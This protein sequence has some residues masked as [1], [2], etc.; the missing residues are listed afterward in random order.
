MCSGRASI[1]RIDVCSPVEARRQEG[2]LEGQHLDQ[3]GKQGEEPSTTSRARRGGGYYRVSRVRCSEQCRGARSEL[4]GLAGREQP[5]HEG[6]DGGLHA[7][8]P[9]FPAAPTRSTT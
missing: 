2:V 9:S 7:R 6:A 8:P 4:L 5:L 3:K 1:S